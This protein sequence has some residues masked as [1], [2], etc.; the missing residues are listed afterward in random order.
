MKPRR[1][2]IMFDSH[3][4]YLA[5][6]VNALQRELVRR[7]LDKTVELHVIL[8]AAD[9]SSYGWATGG[10]Q[11]LYEVPVHVLS[12]EFHGLGLRSFFHRSVPLV[13]AKFAALYL[14]LRPRVTLVGGYDRPT[15]LLCRLLSYPLFAKVGVM[16]DSRFNDA[17]SFSKNVL[18]EFIKS[19]IVARYSFFMVPGRESADYHRFLAGRKAR[20]Y[21]EAWDIV[22]NDTIAAAAT[23]SSRDSEIHE[24][25][26][27]APGTPYFFMPARFVEK[28]NIPTVLRAYASY[29]RTLPEGAAVHRLVLCG[30]GPEEAAIKD[31]ITTLALDGKVTICPWL[32]YELMPR[33]CRLGT[34]LILASHHD[35]W[36]MTVN[37]SLCAGTPV[38]VS[39]RCG[40]HELVRN[41]TNGYTFAPDD[42]PHLSAL[43]LRLHND[44]ALVFRLREGCAP[45]ME[46]FSIQQYV[47]R[48]VEMLADNGFAPPVV[49]G[50]IINVDDR[51]PPPSDE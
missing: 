48:H 6:R 27:I 46:H 37:E 24:R 47:A 12:K 45:S 17:E 11:G 8:V 44:P 4:P 38:L 30:Q 7:G 1:V 35:Q 13:L 15:S 34:A 50:K 49:F 5:F 3:T 25:L 9:W 31:L 29:L 40:A 22:D 43:M 36:G 23:D 18:I 2:A 20:V 26:G 16:N 10:L 21:T 33:A 39:N 42:T 28:K 51:L 14:K 41:D 19:L 32:P